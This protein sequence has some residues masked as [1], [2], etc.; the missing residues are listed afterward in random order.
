MNEKGEIKAAQFISSENNAVFE[1]PG[2]D[3]LTVEED[4]E[5]LYQDGKVL[6]KGKKFL[7][8]DNLIETFGNFG[9]FAEIEGNSIICVDCK[10]GDVYLKNLG[11]VPASASIL[12][13][14]ILVNYGE[15]NYK[16]NKFAV[17]EANSVFVANPGVDMSGYQGNWIRQ[18]SDILEIQSSKTGNGIGIEFLENHEILNTDN[19]DLL[20][21]GISHGDG[22]VFEKRENQFLIP[23]LTHKSS[24]NGVTLIKNDNIDFIINKDGIESLWTTP[25]YKGDFSGKYQSVAFELYGSLKNGGKLRVDSH[26]LFALVD[27]NNFEIVINS[28]GLPVSASIA[29][30]ELQTIEQLREKY[31]NIEFYIPEFREGDPKEDGYL[32]IMGN[33][34]NITGVSPYHVYVIKCFLE[35]YPDAVNKINTIG[36]VNL[37]NAGVFTSGSDINLYV[38]DKV[39]NIYGTN[40][41]NVR[42]ITNPLDVLYHE[43]IH[44]KDQFYGIE[45]SQLMK[46]EPY[47]NEEIEKIN[48]FIEKRDFLMILLDN[49]KD[50]ENEKEISEK[51]KELNEEIKKLDSQ[52]KEKWYEKNPDNPLLM[53]IYNQMALEAQK[54]VLEH[55]QN[56]VELM[57]EYSKNQ[58][59]ESFKKYLPALKSYVKKRY[60]K[61]FNSF[62]KENNPYNINKN[63]EIDLNP[64]DF[65]L[66]LNDVANNIPGSLYLD[67]D[68]LVLDDAYN[69][70]SGLRTLKL[71]LEEEQGKKFFDAFYEVD[72]KIS[73]SS[74]HFRKHLETITGIPYAYAFTNYEKSEHPAN[75]YFAEMSAVFWE[76][77][78]SKLIS[79]ANS[80]NSIIRN[81][82]RKMTQIGFDSS[83]I[84]K[85]EY[86]KIM[87]NYHCESGDCLDKLCIEYKLLCCQKYPASP[88]CK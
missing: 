77:P 46:N 67:D 38:G 18:T 55:R 44:V 52:I 2:L 70:L 29:D 85:D 22:F 16:Q 27:E 62:L 71:N 32:P 72:G 5:I 23:K 26:S 3:K 33:S 69:Y 7:Y 28:N 21:I 9:K 60:D 31:P 68:Y 50:K 88:N 74:S 82:C 64:S 15:V 20:Q 47:F 13:K 36:F 57:E 87:G 79:C 80:E 39:I 45:E 49:E 43:F 73:E 86:K 61:D 34:L 83:Q 53:Q 14:G 25:L 10:V 66:L 56:F 1:F 6:V 42:G 11:G 41:V 40:S 12:D 19:K 48:K 37:Y 65:V 58:E 75:A 4:T 35:K 76:R 24:E 63:S 30:N 78:I 8:G 84:D 17:G 51:I 81:Y 59:S 54:E